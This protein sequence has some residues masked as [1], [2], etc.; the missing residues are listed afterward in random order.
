[1][2]R[3]AGEESEG[4]WTN[5]KA[6]IVTEFGPQSS[7]EIRCRRPING[8]KGSLRCGRLVPESKVEPIAISPSHAFELAEI[9]ELVID[10]DE[11][12]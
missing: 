10:R 1:M 5:A 4:P 8:R 2:A 11:V 7:W 12:D 3:Q 9:R 6:G